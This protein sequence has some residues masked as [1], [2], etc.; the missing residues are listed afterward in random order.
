MNSSKP[1]DAAK[2]QNPVAATARPNTKRLVGNA[3]TSWQTVLN[4]L[5]W[6]GLMLEEVTPFTNTPKGARLRDQL[7]DSIRWDATY[8]IRNG[9]PLP[10]LSAPANGIVEQ[11]AAA[12]GRES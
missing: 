10:A 8:L 9:H 4:R 5:Y 1:P 2:A 12:E 6:T 11:I 3:A 7:R